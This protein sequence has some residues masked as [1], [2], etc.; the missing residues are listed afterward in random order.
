MNRGL[1]GDP[2]DIVRP[3]APL[4]Y[5][6][7]DLRH[8][9][10]RPIA[11][12]RSDPDRGY[13]SPPEGSPPVRGYAD[14]EPVRPGTKSRPGRSGRPKP[15]GPDSDRMPIAQTDRRPAGKTGPGATPP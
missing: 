5:Q 11:P 6:G 12:L 4:P 13:W 14:P 7:M 3:A 8:R 15:R 10:E 2:A 1:E 9:R